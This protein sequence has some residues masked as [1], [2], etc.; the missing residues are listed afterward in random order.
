MANLP[1]VSVFLWAARELNPAGGAAA[2]DQ[3]Q[4]AR[5]MRD[6]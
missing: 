3:K 5:A 1:T 2:V 4:V 6:E